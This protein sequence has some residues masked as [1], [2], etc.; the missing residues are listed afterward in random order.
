M[1]SFLEGR[2]D[3]SGWI[4]GAKGCLDRNQPLRSCGLK[5]SSFLLSASFGSKGNLH[6]AFQKLIRPDADTD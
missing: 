3:L 1:A 2:K 5:F 6:N 4:D